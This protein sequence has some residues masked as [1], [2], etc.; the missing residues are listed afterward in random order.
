MYGDLDL[1]SSQT[2]IGQLCAVLIFGM[3][4]R[5]EVVQAINEKGEVKVY[6]IDYG[7]I[8]LVPLHNLKFLLKE[9]C[10]VPSQAF[11]GCLSRIQPI[12]PRWKREAGFYFL[13]LLPDAMIYAKVDDIDY[14]VRLCRLKYLYCVSD[15]I[16]DRF[17][18]GSSTSPD[19][20]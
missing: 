6:C 4:H 5:A 7:T 13:S 16:I 12:G 17:F 1:P 20:N 2:S 9:F 19:F 14:E 10:A 15:V 3:W 18:A 8:A 11:R